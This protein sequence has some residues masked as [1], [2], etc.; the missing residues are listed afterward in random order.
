RGRGRTF[1]RSWHPYQFFRQPLSFDRRHRQRGLVILTPPAGGAGSVGSPIQTDL[2]GV[3]KNVNTSAYVRL[4][5]TVANPETFDTLDLI[6]GYNDGFVAYLNGIEVARR[7]AP[8][9]L[10][11][12]SSAT[13]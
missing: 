6:I 7:A 9:S 8:A 11:Y 4:P 2:A 10:S 5:F 3:M 13:A 1:R 12:N